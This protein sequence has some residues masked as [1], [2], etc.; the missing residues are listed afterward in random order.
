MDQEKIQEKKIRDIAE[1]VYTEKTLKS[2]YTVAQVPFHVHSGTDSSPV[3]EKDL[4]NNIKNQFLVQNLIDDGAPHVLVFRNIPNVKRL[5]LT[6]A[7]GDGANYV[8]INGSSVFGRIYGFQYISGDTF[9]PTST[10]GGEAVGSVCNTLA[11]APG[12]STSAD[13]AIF[14]G[15]IA[16]TPFGEVQMQILLVTEQFITVTYTVQPGWNFGAIVQLF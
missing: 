3:N 16:A 14:V 7:A 8:I 12:M 9:D 15:Y 6:G 11:I 13:V 4:V 1:A 10:A 5:V 2:K